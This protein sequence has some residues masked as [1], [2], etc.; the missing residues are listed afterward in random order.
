MQLDRL[1][2]VDDILKESERVMRICNA[3]RYCE[4][5]CAV[6][7]AMERRRAFKEEDLKYLANLCHN[8]RGCYYACQYAPPHEFALNIPKTFSELR[9]E[10]YQEFSWPAFLAN[11]FK[12]NSLKL[13]I[14]SILCIAVV[15]MAAFSLKGVSGVLSVYQGEGAFY[16]VIPYPLMVV[17]FSVLGLYIF[18]ALLAGAIRF[19][20]KT[21]NQLKELFS[22]RA[23]GQA[24]WDA[25]RLKYLD[26]GGY[27]CNYPDERF[28]MARRW[29]HHLMF[30]GFLFCLASTTLAAVYHHFLND[31][32]PYPFWSW[33][34]MLGTLG[35][36]ALLAG[37]GGLL[38]LKKHMDEEPSYP[39]AFPMDMGLLVLLFLI[40]LSGILLLV[41]RE[42]GAMGI[43]LAVH[44]GLVAG[45]FITL[46]YG[47]FVH[48]VYRYLALLRNAC[49]ESK[50][51][52]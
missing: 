50:E 6:F 21:E 25:L 28:S 4:G 26:G 44:I 7:P 29:F 15:M 48:A 16:R 14:I 11:L 13:F 9:V 38:Y 42:T 3:C 49:E 33:P 36:V 34:V 24:V 52:R 35:G 43:L 2:P 1:E 31:P 39:G 32:A 37:T 18:S 30:Y 8:C 22:L 45:L 47:K 27:G 41:F 23:N 51:K 5:L 40:S 12:R 19:W 20:R 46:P 17:P 10:T